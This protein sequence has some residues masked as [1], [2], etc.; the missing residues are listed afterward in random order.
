MPCPTFGDI[1]DVIALA[2]IL[3]LKQITTGRCL[4]AIAN[5]M[6]LLLQRY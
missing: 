4:F 5:L 3:I 2:K 1:S 6:L